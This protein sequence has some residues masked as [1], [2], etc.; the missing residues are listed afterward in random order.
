MTKII[1]TSKHK[2]EMID[3][4]SEIKEE[5]IKSGV[6]DGVCVITAQHTTASIM[7]FEKMDPN[8]QRDFLSEIKR[9]I[10]D[11]T[12]YSHAGGNGAAHMKASFIGSTVSLPVAN[13]CPM[14]GEWQGI[15]FTDFDGPRDRTVVISVV[16]G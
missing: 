16:N 15:F 13:A 10:P 11:D 3:I 2:T 1:V 7:L 5:I 4:T 9:K 8:L 14:I 6:K 12:A